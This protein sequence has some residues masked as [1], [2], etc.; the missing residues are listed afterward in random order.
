MTA[1]FEAPALNWASALA[2]Q[3]QRVFV[4]PMAG[5]IASW[6]L[7]SMNTAAWWRDRLISIN[8]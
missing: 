3:C 5:R 6:S 8:L 4:Q 1:I 2:V 7:C